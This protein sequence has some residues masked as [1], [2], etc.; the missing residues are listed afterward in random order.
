MSAD[1]KG[2]V[3]QAGGIL[4]PRTLR[5]TGLDRGLSAALQPSRHVDPLLLIS[6]RYLRDDGCAQPSGLGGRRRVAAI[7]SGLGAKEGGVITALLGR[8]M[9][10]GVLESVLAAVRDGLSG[11]LVLRGEAGI[12]KTALLDWAAGQAGD[13]QLARVVG[14]ESEMDLGLV[15][16][17]REGEEPT[18]LLPGLPELTVTGLAEEVAHELLAASAGAPVD[19]QVSRQIAAGT[20]G[21]PLALVELAGVLSE[22]ELSGA[23]PVTW[24]LRSGGRLEELYLSRVRALP[25]GTQ[26]LLLLAAADASGEP[27]LIW[28]AAQSLGTDPEAGEV[29]G[30]ERLVAWEPRVRFRHPLIRSAAYYAAPVAARRG[31][32]RVLAAATDAGRDPDRRAW[33]LAEAAPG[34]DEQVA[35]ELERSASRAR[36]RGGWQS[37]AVFLERAA[38]LTPDAGRRAQRVL[39]AAETRLLAGDVAAARTLLEDAG[40]QL[41]EPLARGLARRLEGLIAFAAGELPAATSVLLDAAQM[42]GPH[43][44]RL[45][46]DT[47][48][49]ALGAAFFSGRFGAGVGQVLRAVRLAPR[50]ADSQATIGDLLLDGF[51]ALDEHRDEVGV[52]SLR[53][54]LASLADDQPL[55]GDAVQLF[56]P[57][58]AAIMLH[59]DPASYELA[60]R[61]AA[62]A[63]DRGA[64]AALLMTLVFLAYSQL[65]EGRFADAEVTVAEGRPLSEATGYRAHLGGFAC[66]EL[67]VLAWRGREA[68]A[69]PLAAQILRDLTAQG[70]GVGVRLAHRALAVLEL[71]LG[72]YSQALHHAL[73]TLEGR[74]LGDR[75]RADRGGSQMWGLRD[76]QRRFGRVRVPVAGQRDP[77]AL[78]LLARSRALLAGDGR[79]E[80][81]YRLAIDHLGQTRAAPEL[82]RA[83]LLYG[84]WLRRQRRRKDARHQ[85]RTAYE[86]SVTLGMDAFAG[87]ARAELGATGERARPRGPGA[88]EV[89]TPQEAQIARLVAEGG[90]N[91]EVAARLFISPATVEY[92]VRKVYQKLEVTSRTQLASGF[93]LNQDQG[94]DRALR[95]A[96]DHRAAPRRSW[97]LMMMTVGDHPGLPRR[98]PLLRGQPQR[99]P[100]HEAAAR[101][102]RWRA[103]RPGPLGEGSHAERPEHLPG[104]AELVAGVAAPSLAA[105][106][107]A[108]EQ[109]GAGLLRG[110]PAA[111]QV[112]DSQLVLGS[113]VVVAGEQR[114]AAG[115]QAEGEVGSAGQRQGGERLEHRGRGLVVAASGRCFDHCLRP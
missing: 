66:A 20:A 56:M 114:P 68:D 75:S 15:F 57:H 28:Q 27:A 102:P 104:G 3:S 60:R 22:A 35:A 5:V 92:H 82:A 19:R 110:H 115:Q 77:R 81:H 85:L 101:S 7:C 16:T 99:R 32:H 8:T 55:P 105:Q 46:R 40:S 29:A 74:G 65:R 39:D 63:R 98:R 23:V 37:S 76:R 53:R 107:L 51:A 87:R 36:A 42:V 113:G 9:E 91:R 97:S 18:A 67:E 70:N 93:R 111:V 34:P 95:P 44:A 2:L 17:V 48:L 14:V 24:P 30:V 58:Q 103:T 79:A 84:E 43:D 72:N 62:E 33:H 61:S 38:Q 45:A 94:P 69:R 90:T 13:M 106:P 73:D 6:G 10:T 31:A 12:G 52:E 41:E 83:H 21:N 64:L 88:P 50:V 112:I 47:L 59:D 1:G 54:A 108:V 80:S 100:R 78:G 89:L 11:V 109:V 26:A 49:D 4:L 96:D 25:P 86:M 71:S